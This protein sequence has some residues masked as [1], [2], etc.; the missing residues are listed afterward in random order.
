MNYLQDIAFDNRPHGVL[1]FTRD[2]NGK[3]MYRAS[4]LKCTLGIE[5]ARMTYV[6]LENPRR[7]E[8]K[9]NLT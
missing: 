7:L 3:Y 6:A 9:P 2:V 8:V 1:M 4:E 5:K